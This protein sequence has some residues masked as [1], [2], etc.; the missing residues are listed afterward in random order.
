M[1]SRTILS[2]MALMTLLS[3]PVRACSIPVFRYALEQWRPD[4]YE[5]LVFLD[6]ELTDQQ[7][8]WLERLNPTFDPTQPF[9]NTAVTLVNLN[10]E[11]K[12]EFQ[13]IWQREE[14]TS[15]PWVL[16]RTP[17]K[18]NNETIWAGPLSEHHVNKLLDSPARREL[19]SRLIKG[20]SVVWIL[21]DGQNAEENDAKERLLIQELKRLQK[22]VKLPEIELED[23]KDLTVDPDQLALRFSVLR[24]NPKDEQERLLVE[25]LRRV[26]PDLRDPELVQQPMAFPIFGRARAYYPLVGKGI[27][28]DQIEE[29]TRFLCGACQCTVKQQ[30]PGLDL[31]TSMNW[32]A[33][34]QPAYQDD[35]PLPPLAG[36]AGFADDQ[37]DA[38]MTS[39]ETSGEG[40][41]SSPS[42]D[43]SATADSHDE[44][45]QDTPPAVDPSDGT[46]NLPA[47][48]TRASSAG[49]LR[50]NILL[51]AGIV[52][53]L[54]VL[55]SLFVT[56]R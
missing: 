2:V 15:L 53:C 13:E 43:N 33:Y 12:P 24:I 40:T 47:V 14:G 52:T 6:G 55:G 17:Y 41:S 39:T 49:W 32:D 7:K 3:A 44:Q 25:M 38:D 18:G 20:D 1:R 5:V 19:A 31:M 28:K 23:L 29:L 4:P 21:L 8:A 56:K 50:R 54:V 11:P 27:A 35:R 46:S 36:L 16:V 22:E 51:I 9:P 45:A 34:V 48:R 30:N 37:T 42:A 10:D 26:E